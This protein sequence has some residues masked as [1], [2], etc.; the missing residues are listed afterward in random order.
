MLEV[1]KV[2]VED[3]RETRLLNN[4]EEMCLFPDDFDK[5]QFVEAVQLLSEHLIELNELWMKQCEDFAILQRKHWTFLQQE[6]KHFK[7]RKGIENI[8]TKILQDHPDYKEA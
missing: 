7:A 6:A 8:L 4:L 5:E 3:E 2:L 1:T